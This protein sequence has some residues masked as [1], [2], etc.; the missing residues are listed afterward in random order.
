MGW[1]NT[2]ASIHERRPLLVCQFPVPGRQLTKLVVAGPLGKLDLGNEHGFYPMAAF[3]DCWGNALTPAP[4]SLLWQVREGARW[5]LD[6][7]EAV[8]QMLQG[9]LGETRADSAGE[10]EAVRALVA[11]KQSAEVVSVRRSPG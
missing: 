3:H 10:Q 1:L 6:L 11:D 9:F 4:G 8:V 5:P 2:R 7:L